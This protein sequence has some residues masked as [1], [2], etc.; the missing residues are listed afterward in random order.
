[1]PVLQSCELMCADVSLRHDADVG[2]GR[3]HGALDLSAGRPRALPAN[4]QGRIVD[5]TAAPPA[6]SPNPH[7]EGRHR[8]PWTYPRAHQWPQQH[9]STTNFAQQANRRADATGCAQSILQRWRLGRE[10]AMGHAPTPVCSDGVYTKPSPW[11]NACSERKQ[12]QVMIL[13]I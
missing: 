11:V 1:M 7:R 6:P 13:P 5:I 10:S 2:R 8:E 3:Q 4:C 12:R 9:I